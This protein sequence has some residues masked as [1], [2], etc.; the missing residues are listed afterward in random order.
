MASRIVGVYSIGAA[1]AEP[2]GQRDAA[3][4]LRRQ[5]AEIEDDQAEASAFEQQVGGAE[6]L[7][8]AMVGLREAFSFTFIFLRT[9]FSVKHFSSNQRGRI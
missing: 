4:G 6:D 1:K 7:L 3:R 5:V 8:Q 9:H 2:R